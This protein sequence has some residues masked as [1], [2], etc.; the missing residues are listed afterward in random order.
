MP[1]R[2]RRMIEPLMWTHRYDNTL[3]GLPKPFN[4]PYTKLDNSLAIFMW[5]IG[6]HLRIA[7]YKL[8]TESID[9]LRDSKQCFIVIYGNWQYAPPIQMA[10]TIQDRDC[11][12]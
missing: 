8:S 9:T 12:P 1:L 6:L 3:H 10:Q 5:D 11:A 4:D 7:P 2:T